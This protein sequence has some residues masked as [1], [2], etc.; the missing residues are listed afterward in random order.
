M[1]GIYR[2]TNKNTNQSYVGKT[3]NYENR[4]KKHRMLLR[5]N[6]HW[7]IPL[8]ASWDQYGEENFEFEFIEE[9]NMKLID[10]KERYYIIKYRAKEDGFN[11]VHGKLFS[12]K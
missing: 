8:Q 2:I 3:T 6:R 9:C 11:K 7:N 12:R 10:K 4:F 1:I 5:S